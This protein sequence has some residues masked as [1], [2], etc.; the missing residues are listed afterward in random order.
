MVKKV[1]RSKCGK[2]LVLSCLTVFLLGSVEVHALRGDGGYAAPYFQADF[3]QS[4]SEWASPLV[5]PAL[6]YRVNQKHFDI[7]V[8]RF[9]LLQEGLGYQQ[10]GF[11]MPLFRNHTVGLTGLWVKNGV[12]QTTLTGGVVQTL[13]TAYF[14]DLWLIPS[15]GVKLLPWLMVG[16]NLKL[17]LERQFDTLVHFMASKVPGL[18][19]GFYLNPL[20]NYRN[21]IGDWGLSVCL[22]DIV[23]TAIDWSNVGS[24]F[25]EMVVTRARVG[26]RWSG[27]N[28]NVVTDFEVVVD[29]ALISLFKAIKWDA[30]L[31][32]FLA[33]GA[34]FADELFLAARP[35]FHAKFMFS[36]QLWIKGGWNNNN[37][38]YIGFNY[39]LIYLLPEMINYLN[40]DFHMGY[41]FLDWSGTTRDERG[42]TLMA[43]VGT[44]FGQTR[45]Q[46]LSR[47]LYDKLILAPMD[48]YN[49]AM[50]LYI[51][52]KYWEAGFAFGKVLSLYPNFHLNDKAK[53]YLGD[54]YSKLYMNDI[55]REVFREALEEYTTSEQR[56][57]YIYGLQ[58]I[59][60]REGKYDEALQNHA[61]IINL[62]PES[63]IRTDADYLAGEIQFQRKN[64]NVAEQLFS[65]IKPGDPAYLYAQ[66]TMAVINIEN[67]KE[68]AA[69]QNLNT[70]TKDST[71]EASDQLLQ[72]AANLKLGHL[73]FE[74]GDKLRQ[75]V[76]AYNRVPD[77]SPYQ[78]EALLATAWSWMKVN[79]PNEAYE[80]SDRMLL[81]YPE[82]PLVPETF[83]VK[84]YAQM[85]LKRY[86]EAVNTLEQCLTAAKR[87]FVTERDLQKHRAEFE[88]QTHKFAPTAEKIKKNTL[89][90]PTNVVLKERTE[91]VSEFDKYAR[92]SRDFFNQ[93][94]LAKSH[95]RFFKRKDE[96][97]ADAEYALAKATNMMKTLKSSEI[98][99]DQKENMQKI[100]SEKEK[101]EAEIRELEQQERQ[102]PQ[103]QQ[104]KT[105]GK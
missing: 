89:R 67:N 79:R 9:A 65:K 99:K 72:D 56:S 19:L 48:A 105:P 21:T 69:V 25:Q 87:S 49:E 29:N 74:N 101:I 37:I 50:R 77:G 104:K 41:S 33:E 76:E 38:P 34:S 60:Y 64:Y 18:D 28:D 5:N 27:F 75:A 31:N 52:E 86:V 88:D 32:N 80:T 1:V 54:C 55:A 91:L 15:Y 44:D 70:I 7:G 14:E 84:G 11:V 94:V 35:G 45:E 102:Q 95:Y 100:Q 26:L 3:I 96:V 98:I 10:L 4:V 40:F 62:Y 22:Q 82:S 103:K 81:N 16:A 97:I 12:L 23:P 61:F 93:T 20:D 24:D 83:L 68:E 73:Y 30:Y 47:R 53:W 66:Y 90:K 43:K 51:A 13:G 92:Q 42:F 78:D 85:L 39:N 8:F 46:I 6:L 2:V 63:D 57:R 71:Q 36:P 58:Y 59:D 17:R